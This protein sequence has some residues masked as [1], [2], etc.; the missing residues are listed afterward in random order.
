[1]NQ[2]ITSRSRSASAWH[3]PCK[4][5]LR[6]ENGGTL[7]ETAF[8]LTILFAFLI[9]IIEA[10]LALYSYHFVSDA[11]REGTRYA[12]VRGG[13]W[14]SPCTSYTSAGCNATGAQIAQYVSSL[15]FPGIFITTTANTGQTTDDVFVCYSGGVPSSAPPAC[16]TAP[17]PNTAGGAAGTVV[18]VTV[19]YPFTFGIPGLR[20][21]TY[22]LSS[23]SQMVIAQ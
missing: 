1:M 7:V 23:S 9:G 3:L 19:T 15:N 12:I 11:A 5:R 6:N 17:S 20:K 8:T 13:D 16:T 22:S 14:A 10:S 2:Q 4:G 21:F 18:Q